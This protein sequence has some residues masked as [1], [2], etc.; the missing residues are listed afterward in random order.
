MGQWITLKS[1]TPKPFI[2]NVVYK[3][4]C[5]HDAKTFYFGKTKR[6]FITWFEEQTS[7][8]DEA[9]GDSQV[10]KHLGQSKSVA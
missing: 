7:L 6:H 9:E 1:V 2:S 8:K 5:L 3:F 10:K 4:T